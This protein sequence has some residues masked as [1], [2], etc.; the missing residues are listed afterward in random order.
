MGIRIGEVARRSGRSASALRYY[1]REGL[2]PR[3][4]RRGNARVWSTDVFD[5][6]ALIALARSAGFT[7]AEIRQL[8]GGAPRRSRPG[9][10]WRALAEKKIAEVE[11][12]I[13]EAQRAR[14]VLRAVMGCECATFDDCAR[15]GGG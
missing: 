4:E 12:R 6:L 3:A 5:R 9:P 10:R 15:A 11:A 14:A 13:E 7:V 2:L 1:E 8:L